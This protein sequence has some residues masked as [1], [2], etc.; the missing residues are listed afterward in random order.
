MTQ[1]STRVRPLFVGARKNSTSAPL[2]GVIS[3]SHAPLNIPK[4]NLLHYLMDDFTRFSNK[5]ALVSSG[6]IE[7]LRPLLFLTHDRLTVS[8]DKTGPM[9]S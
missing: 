3:S 8:L 2:N 6:I 1:A 5:V 7:K 9:L 4:I